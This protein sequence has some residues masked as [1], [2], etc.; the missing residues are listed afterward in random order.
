M[1]SI[2]GLARISELPRRTIQFWADKEVLEFNLLEG[3]TEPRRVYSRTEAEIVMLLRPF[4]HLGCPIKLLKLIAGVFRDLLDD[5]Y[6]AAEN[7]IDAEMV[8]AARRGED[9]FVAASIFLIGNQDGEDQFIRIVGMGHSVEELSA[10]VGNQLRDRY[11][12]P[13][14]MFN[15]TAALKGVVRSA[16]RWSADD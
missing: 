14:V 13:I 10:K 15:L 12:L 16:A 2:S 4:A 8:R 5:G 7:Q 3:S 6:L 9:V 1:Y 11:A